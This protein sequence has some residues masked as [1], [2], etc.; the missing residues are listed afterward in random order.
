[1]DG[2]AKHS[3]MNS[4]RNC[5]KQD[6]DGCLYRMD[7]C[8]DRLN[9]C[10][11]AAGAADHQYED[12]L[13]QALP[14]EYKA[15]R[16]AHLE[17]R[18]FGLADIRRIMAAICEDNPARSRSVSFRGIT[19][20]GASM[21]ATTHDRNYIKCH[22]CGC[23]GHFKIKCP[24][25]VNQLQENDE[26]QTP[27]QLKEQQNNPPRQHQRNRGDGQGPVWCSFH[28]TTT[29]SEGD[30]CARRCKWTYGNAHI[31]ATGSL[32]NKGIFIA[33][34]LLESDHQ[35]ERLYASFA[36]IEAHSTEAIAAEKSRKEE[37]WWLA[38]S[39]ASSV[40]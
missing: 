19:G 15:I 14:P 8:H 13:L 35:P 7:R 16:Q 40:T 25:R 37:T 39:I 20:R 31:A 36:A 24:L 29:Y 4:T 34:H 11:P 23:V 12:V 18:D 22:A 9:A 27:Q 26:Q 6:P 21:K 38:V 33:Y 2:T 30:C 17:R 10:D 1:M 5:S 3:E 32:R 28:K